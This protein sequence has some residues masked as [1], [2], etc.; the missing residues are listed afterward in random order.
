MNFRANR[1][2]AA[3]E[4]REVSLV[5]RLGRVFLVMGGVVAGIVLAVTSGAV[6]P[7]GF[8]HRSQSAASLAAQR[9]ASNRAW[10][11]ELCT[12]VVAWKNE[13][14]RDATSLNLGFSP[15]ARV[16]DATAATKRLVHTVEK[17]GPPPAAGSGEAGAEAQ[18][19]RAELQSGA[20]D[21]E[22]L[23]LTRSCRGLAGIPF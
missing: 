18:Q 8:H 12:S 4:P 15:A 19:L 9:T 17:L 5:V 14:H 23:A 7:P 2:R 22:A 11:S 10:A 21:L 16:R 13:L 3:A 6:T 1:N 20:R